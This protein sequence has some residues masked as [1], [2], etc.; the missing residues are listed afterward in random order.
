MTCAHCCF[1]CTTKGHDM[2]QDTFTKALKMA[3]DYGKSN[4]CIGGGEPTM[5]PLFQDF[6][7]QAIWAM[8]SSFAENGI[9]GVHMVTNGSN[10][11]IALKL[12][13]LAYQ[14][15]ISCAL[16]QDKY[17]DPIDT[18]VIKAFT[19]PPRA[20]YGQPRHNEKRDHDF[21]SINGG[22]VYIER[23]GRAK[24]WG[25]RESKDGGCCGGP[26]IHPKGIIYP[27]TC[28]IKPIGTIDDCP[29]LCHEHFCAG[30]CCQSDTY[31]DELEPLMKNNRAYRVAH[32]SVK[33]NLTN[34]EPVLE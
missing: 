5:H 9:P 10:T 28:R 21:R 30:I 13:D 20:L 31:K 4:I 25:N 33:K 7:F 3:N 18:K 19:P 1:S 23:I 17:H 27:C 11:E 32:V 29:D 26:L 8:S 24:S 34:A 14:G 16:S 22:G 6:L 2:T 12:A 15:V